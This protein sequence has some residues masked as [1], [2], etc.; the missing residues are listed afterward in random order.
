MTTS[1]PR[2]RRRPQIGLLAVQCAAILVASLFLIAGVLG[3]V[4]GL[5]SN[6]D[7]L[8]VYGPESEAALFGVFEISVVANL[9]HIVM[10]V[11]GLLLASTYRRSRAYLLLGGL[12]IL[13]LWVYGILVHHESPA[14]LLPVNNADNWLHLGLGASMVILALTLA[15]ARVPTGAA[16]E[17]L[18]PPDE[19]PADY[20]PEEHSAGS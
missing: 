19:L 7:A 16:G 8:K 17:V 5:T 2:L 3:F 10:G 20:K 11:G 12:V 6:L 4:P 1:H 18:L 14:N 15:G 13:G 9:F